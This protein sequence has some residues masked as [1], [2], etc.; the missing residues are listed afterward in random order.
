MNYKGYELPLDSEHVLLDASLTDTEVQAGSYIYN[1]I[2]SMLRPTPTED[3]INSKKMADKKLTVYIMPGVYWIDDPEADDTMQ[4]WGGYDVPYGIAVTAHSLEF[5]GLTDDAEDVVIAGNRGQSHGANGNYTMFHFECESLTIKNLTIG[6]YCS[7]DLEYKR[8]ASRNHRRRT[9][10]ITQAQLAIMQGDRMFADNCRFIGR[11][12]L[13]PVEGA[14]RALYHNC[15][16]ESTNDAIT[17]NAV[18]VGCDFDFY[19][20]RPLFSATR[21]GAVFLDCDFNCLEADPRVEGM[22]Y[23]TKDGGQVA[24]VGCR[25]HSNFDVPFGIGWTRYPDPQ[26]RCYQ[27]DNTHN[28]E[29]VVIGGLRSK[30]TVDM[31]GLPL[32]K[33][34]RLDDYGCY[35]TYNLLRGSDGWDPLNVGVQSGASSADNIPVQLILSSDA[36]CIQADADSVQNSGLS[37][38]TASGE[39]A[40]SKAVVSSRALCFWGGIGDAGNITFY[41][42]DI[43]KDFVNVNDNNDGSCT[44]TGRPEAFC[45]IDKEYVD[46]VIEAV[47]AI[48][49]HGAYKLRI[50]APITEAPQFTKYPELSICNGNAELSYELELNGH[51]DRSVVSWYRC[52][53]SRGEGARLTAI[54]RNSPKLSYKITAA[55]VGSYIGAS[56]IPRCTSSCDGAKVVAVTDRRIADTDTDG[57]DICTDFS[58]IPL[59]M[60]KNIAEGMW[61][62]DYYRPTDTC[63]FGSWHGEEC[64]E[65]WHYGITGDGCTHPGLYQGTQGARIMY[66]PTYRQNDRVKI[67]RGMSLH[68][69]AEPAK[70]SCQGFGSAY[71][72]MDV[73]IK[74]DTENLTGY[75]LRIYRSPKASNACVFVLVQ[76]EEGTTTFISDK[77]ISGCFV[78]ECIIDVKY[79][80][81]SL[82]ADV[83]TTAEQHALQEVHL[84]ADVSDNLH[85]GIAVQHTGTTGTGGWQNTTTLTGLKVSYK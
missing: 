78:S 18:F 16:F 19:G 46:V 57:Y 12:N 68:L 84:K 47:T 9:D 56:V 29:S 10:A 74:F 61:S 41:V 49:L 42:D 26:L 85:G 59:N 1:N 15:H 45:N 52:D 6:N 44:V 81:G 38:G 65:P 64:T 31:S 54:T 17:S 23:F 76:Y 69:T 3:A 72:Y 8:D 66:T 83:R 27:C 33:A 70:T 30:T 48:G 50:A 51:T 20:S 13:R 22:Q 25:Y 55:D 58:D 24:A 28:K 4:P 80:D 34:Y 11:L 43:Y 71:Q 14:D 67:Y 63:S 75:G 79:M 7:T 39:A 35:N 2:Q 32:L 21:T 62:V 5:A 37:A 36:E 73:C 82:T 60:G 77:V 40:S 53:G